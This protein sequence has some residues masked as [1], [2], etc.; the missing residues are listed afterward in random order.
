MNREWDVKSYKNILCL[1]HAEMRKTVLL[2]IISPG[3][4]SLFRNGKMVLKK[5]LMKEEEDRRKKHKADEA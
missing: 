4:S 5:L 1:V 3:P 2:S